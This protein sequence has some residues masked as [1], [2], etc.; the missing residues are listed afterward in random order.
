MAARRILS[1]SGC[2]HKNAKFGATF[3][4]KLR[5]PTAFVSV[6]GKS[7]AAS[8]QIPFNDAVSEQQEGAIAERTPSTKYAAEDC[9]Q[10]LDLSFRDTEEAYRSKP[11]WELLRA[12]SVLKISSYDFFVDRTDTVSRA[13]NL[14]QP[15][16]A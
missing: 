12:L 10:K 4:R 3:N 15:M 2:F 7:A 16:S 14:P 11:T 1:V 6:R 13:Y 5:D 8:S 9:Y